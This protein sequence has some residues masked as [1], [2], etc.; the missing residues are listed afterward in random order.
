MCRRLVLGA[1]F[2]GGKVVDGNETHHLGIIVPETLS[3]GCRQYVCLQC[4]IDLQRQIYVCDLTLVDRLP[5]APLERLQLDCHLQG[6]L[7]QA[8]WVA[9]LAGLVDAIA[10]ALP[11]LG[12]VNDQLY[13]LLT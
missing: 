2:L 7:Q 13:N 3:F 1:E 5:D 11:G 12:R 9:W 8:Q 10:Q 6:L 4:L